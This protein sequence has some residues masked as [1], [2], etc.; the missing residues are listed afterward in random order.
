M[1]L[2]AALTDLDELNRHLDADP[3][4]A[5]NMLHMGFVKRVPFQ[6]DHNEATVSKYDWTDHGKRTMLERLDQGAQYR[7]ATGQ[8]KP[9]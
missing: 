2:F 5:R 3:E 4:L 6:L 8:D 7:F 9:Q 1:S